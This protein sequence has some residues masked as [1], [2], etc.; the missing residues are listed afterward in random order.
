MITYMDYIFYNF[1]KFID[2]QIQME[3]VERFDSRP[4]PLKEMFIYWLLYVNA[5]SQAPSQ[6]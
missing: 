4:L 6:A 3:M 5:D 1:G 2:A